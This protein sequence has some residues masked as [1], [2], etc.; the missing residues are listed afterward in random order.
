MPD[1][2]QSNGKNGKAKYLLTVLSLITLL[3]SGFLWAL[4]QSATLSTHTLEMG[5]LNAESKQQRE[6]INTNAAEFQNFKG[7]VDARLSNIEKSLERIE[8]KMDERK[9]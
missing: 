3:I 5:T 2:T 6:K 4:S 9:K 1:Q 8:R 7:S